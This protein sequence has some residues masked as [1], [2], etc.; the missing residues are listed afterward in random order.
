[1][2]PPQLTT[3]APVLNV[4]QPVAIGADI[5]GG[6]ELDFSL[7]YGWQGYLG[8]VLHGEEPLLAQ[9]WLYGCV[10][11]TLAVA[12][13]VLIVLYALHESC[14]LQVYGYLL[15]HLHAVHAHIE[16]GLLREGTVGVEDVYRVQVVGLAQ[17]I[18]I[19]IMGRG[20]LQ[21]SRTELDVH[22]TVLD[23]WYDASH[24]GNRHL[25]STKPLVLDIL[26][27][28]THG[29]VAHDG[30]GTRGG[31]HCI[32]SAIGI[33]M[34]YLSLCGTYGIGVLVGHVIAQMIEVA[35]LVPVHYL[36]GAE[37]RLSLGVPVDHAESTVNQTFVIQVA[38]HT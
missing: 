31:H 19:D 13:L 34:Q 20:Y 38:E 17:L 32:V 22:I 26:G 28:D 24:Q 12:H 14:L 8:K 33:L 6:V 1:M 30:L 25:M 29:G 11:V 16:S 23:D 5:L 27:V 2:S 36:F 9:T 21:T 35:L 15:A 37:H 10:G 3:D 18:V 4:L 7:Q